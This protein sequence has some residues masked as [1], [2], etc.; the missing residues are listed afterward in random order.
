MTAVR[1]V[2]NEA[3]NHLYRG[4]RDERDKLATALTDTTT[5]TVVSTYSLLKP[6]SR[7]CIGLE[8]MYVW[9]LASATATV[10]RG[11]FGTTAATHAAGDVISVNPYVSDAEL[12][13]AL[14]RELQALSAEGLYRVATLDRTYS[15]ST[16]GYDLVASFNE[17]HALWWE[18]SGLTSDYHP[19]TAY[20]VARSMPTDDFPSS[21]ALLI[22][23][24]IRP[25]ATIR[26][27]Y[28]AGFNAVSTLVQDVEGISG[29]H[30]EA[31]G[32]LAVGTA[33]RVAAGKPMRRANV[34]GEG[35]ARRAEE[36]SVSDTISAPG[37][38]RV[39]RRD[40]LAAEVTRLSRRYPVT[41]KTRAM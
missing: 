25:G 31:I 38:L 4:Q 1:D 12:L 21:T 18:D 8:D 36:V 16:V 15:A 10:D 28:K 29:I 39:L 27:Q 33:L 11:Q 7:I 35:N 32:L 14:N 13:S 3:R 24:A 19:I 5:S 22:H 37:P 40:L 20:T 26:I 2:L 6:R 34:E 30:P 23:D 41:L 9:S 17:V